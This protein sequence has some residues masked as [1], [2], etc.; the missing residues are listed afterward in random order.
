[1]VG[2]SQLLFG[3]GARDL[4]AAA[5]DTVRAVKG[6]RAAQDQQAA[7]AL[8]DA[9]AQFGAEFR[10]QPRRT[11][12]D[13]LLDGLNRLPRPLLT[14]ATFG[15]FVFAFQDPIGF[16]ARMNALA[17]IPEP[18]W[19]LLGVVV[20]FYFGSRHL[21]KRLASGPSV[22][23]VRQAVDAIREIEGME[24]PIVIDPT[25]TPVQSDNPALADWRAG[26]G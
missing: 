9:M 23:D 10:I 26:Q 8:S 25:A 14:F 19:W 15:L 12:F 13:A 1:M 18:L 17:L 21:E 22:T 20:S 7:S 4:V 2:L 11:W 3:G 16:S 24:A 5:T 6:D